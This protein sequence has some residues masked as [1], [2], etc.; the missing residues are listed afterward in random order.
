[1]AYVIHDREPAALFHFFEDISAI[2]RGSGNEAGIADY[3]V[4]FADTHG[5]DAVRDHLNNVFIVRPAAP[6]WEDRP[7]VMLQAHT[8]MVC[9]QNS[10][11]E[12]DFLNQPIELMVK[13]N[14]LSARGTTLGGDDG[15]GVAIMLALLDDS[16]CPMPRLECLFTTGEETGLYGASGFDYSHITA[17]RIINLDSEEESVACVS[18]AGSNDVTFTYA[19]DTIPYDNTGLRLTIKGLAGGHSGSDI[20]KFRANANGL[21]GRILSYAYETQPFNLISLNGGN[22]LN[23]IPRECEARL[24]VFDPDAFRA[25]VDEITAVIRRELSAEDKGFTVRI[26]KL[27]VSERP[28]TM[29]T[30]QSTGKILAFLRTIKCGLLALSPDIPGLPELSANLSRVTTDE[31]KFTVQMMARSSRAS[32]MDDLMSIYRQTAKLTG[33]SF[34]ID[35]GYP[36]WDFQRNSLL[37]KQFCQVY[38][39]LFPEG[40]MPTL[41]AIHAGLECGLISGALGSDADIISIGPDMKNIHTPDESMDLDSF[42]RVYKLTRCLVSM[43]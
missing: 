13:D 19:Y 27:K 1:M 25:R 2:P 43:T 28:G 24:A 41:Q 17:R 12:H 20:D 22:K 10:G 29:M 6:G 4:H 38:R 35:S 11:T 15:A 32:S 18:C 23:A 5:Y 3:L 31:E 16:D 9:E 37:Q 7:P 40:K 42:A 14:I 21:A 36:G 33:M 39:E 8:D 34:V 30:F 26:D